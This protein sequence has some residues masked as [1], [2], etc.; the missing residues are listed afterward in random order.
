MKKIYDTI[1]IGAGVSGLLTAFALHKRGQKVL[2]I[3]KMGAMSGGSGGAGAF[4][5]P[6]IG[7]D[8]TLHQFTN[9]A[10]S[11]AIDFYKR[12]MP[13]AFSQTGVIRMPKDA[14]DSLKFPLYEKANYKNYKNLSPKDLN[15][16]GI[17]SQ[18][19]AFLFEEAGVIEPHEVEKAVLEEIEICILEVTTLIKENDLWLIG[20]EKAK[21]IVLATGYK[22]QL[23]DMRYMDIR[24]S[25]GVRFDAFTSKVF[26]HSLHENLSISATHNGVIKIGATHELQV[27][28]EIPC[29][30]KSA[31]KLLNMASL[32]VDTSDFE[33]KELFCG[34]RANSRDYFPIVGGVVD[35]AY[36]LENF[37]NL[38]HGSKAWGGIKMVEGLFVC[39]GLGARGFVFAPLVAEMLA[40]LIVDKKAI[41]TQIDPTRLFLGW[42]RR[43]KK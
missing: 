35:V 23:I 22:E 30:M 17:K 31:Q 3:D 42:C 37:P 32:L 20:E 13:N 38:I 27:K 34:M 14:K 16:F 43:G 11:Y 10:F 24:S 1:V 12:Y 39:N 19:N 33:I 7:N 21:N 15:D 5:S 26:Q 9:D 18:L 2:I 6:K 25:W 41:N 40:D 4:I 28:D 36:M 8:G 29:S